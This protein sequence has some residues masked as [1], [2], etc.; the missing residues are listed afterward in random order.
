MAEHLVRLADLGAWL[1]K[2]AADHRDLLVVVTLVVIEGP[3]HRE[4][5]V[6]RAGQHMGQ[7]EAGKEAADAF[8]TRH[9][10]FDACSW[11]RR[12][13]FAGKHPADVTAQQCAQGGPVATC[14]RFKIAPAKLHW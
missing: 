13:A 3:V 10:R 14:T 9:R 5:E 11:S 2:G 12:R 4:R 8:D 7:S 1:L 6:S